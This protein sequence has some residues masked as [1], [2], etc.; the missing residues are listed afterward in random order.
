MEARPR[1]FLSVGAKLAACIVAVLAVGSVLVYTQL[2]DRER[3]HVLASKEHWT[4][5]VADLFVAFVAP[6]LDFSDAEGIESDV[7]RASENSELSR[8]AVFD[9]DRAL[10][11]AWSRDARRI[12]VA[13]DER[14]LG[15]TRL[16]HDELEVTRKVVGAAGEPVGSAV[17]VFSLERENTLYRQSRAQIL[18]LTLA[19]AFVIGAVVL[20]LVRWQIVRPLRRLGEASRRLE[21]GEHAKV[22]VGANDEIGHLAAAFN[23]MGAAVLERAERMQK[24]LE[25]ARRIQTAILPRETGVEGFEIAASMTP[26]SEVGGDYYDV[27][28]APD[29]CWIGIGD[30]SGHG[31]NAGLIMLMIQSSVATLVSRDSET[32]PSA[33]LSAANRILYENVRNRMASDD[34]ATLSLLRCR[35]DGTIVF[36]GA[37]EEILVYRVGERRVETFATPGTWL[38]AMRD[39]SR[40]M[41]DTRIE[42][43]PGDLAVLYTDGLIEARNEQRAS[44][45]IERLTQVIEAVGDQPVEIVHER[46]LAELGAWTSHPDDD[47]TVLVVRR[48]ASTSVP[49]MPRVQSP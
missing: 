30:V 7:A 17:L 47:V 48:S 21:R 42:L 1:R 10:V 45:G 35:A 33:V 9:R 13:P 40:A 5:M 49:D 18:G 31:V 15:R 43:A 20:L 29:G 41:V 2:S 34:H 28:P 12:G 46:V 36:A 23:L 32:A 27:L 39:V 22:A 16:S 26:A 44:F 6:R 11:K 4:E 37:H 14:D 8:V 24:E 3:R 25:I 38:G 19:L